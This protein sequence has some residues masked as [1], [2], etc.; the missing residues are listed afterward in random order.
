VRVYFLDTWAI[1]VSDDNAQC[2]AAEAEGLEVLRP[3]A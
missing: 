2:R 1:V 3:A